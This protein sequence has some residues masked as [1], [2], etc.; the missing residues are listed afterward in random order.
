M[1]PSFGFC[2]FFHCDE[3]SVFM[4]LLPVNYLKLSGNHQEIIHQNRVASQTVTAV[5]FQ[6]VRLFSSSWHSVSAPK[7]QHGVTE[8][9]EVRTTKPPKILYVTLLN[10]MFVAGLWCFTSKGRKK[11]KDCQWVQFSLDFYNYSCCWISLF[12]FFIFREIC[13][14]VK[15]LIS[16]NHLLFV[17]LK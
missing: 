9:F 4:S 7:V 16:F 11:A 13:K 5:S 3:L 14:F 2:S 12:L 15:N 17:F 1:K 10:C 8:V 6:L